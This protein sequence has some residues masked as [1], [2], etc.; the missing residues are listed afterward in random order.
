MLVAVAVTAGSLAPLYAQGPAQPDA[1]V[2]M[3]PPRAMPMPTMPVL[4]PPPPTAVRPAS[5]QMVVT[6]QPVDGQLPQPRTFGPTTNLY[7]QNMIS[8]MATTYPTMPTPAPA[9]LWH[10]YGAAPTGETAPATNTPNHMTNSVPMPPSSGPSVPSA[11]APVLSRPVP[12]T[13]A[14]EPVLTAP[15][16]LPAETQPMPSGPTAAPTIPVNPETADWRQHGAAPA[17]TPPVEVRPQVPADVPM[18]P[19]AAI[20]PGWKSA[21]LRAPR[22]A[23]PARPV[24]AGP[25]PWTTAN[26]RPATTNPTTLASASTPA[27][28]WTNPG[29]LRPAAPGT[30]TPRAV[31]DDAVRPAVATAPRQDVRQATYTATTSPNPPRTAPPPPPAA[32]AGRPIVATTTQRPAPSANAASQ[33]PAQTAAPAPTLASLKASIERVC[34]GRGRDL[35]VI[36]RAPG[37]LLVRVKVRQTGD[38]DYLAHRISELP[39]LGPYKI[40]YEMQVV[41]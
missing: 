5:G 17:V 32:T 36:A 6:G 20:D 11:A 10:G 34:V 4:P 38:A 27:Q 31:P 23:N 29:T 16:P 28:Q 2:R 7:A 21:S 8:G 35:E 40:L 24:P 13:T 18:P 22:P 1:A 3:L 33:R 15:R 30:Y 19:P 39:E 37:N 41:R 9:W 26:A 12:M 14:E 25:E